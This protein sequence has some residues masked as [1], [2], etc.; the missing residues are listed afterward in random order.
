[1]GWFNNSKKSAEE[2]LAD[3][4]L[5]VGPDIAAV[6]TIR[7]QFIR[8]QSMQKTSGLDFLDF[9]GVSSNTR[10]SHGN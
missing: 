1:M 6:C 5:L 4:I 10:N 8:V 2:R 9:V 3:N 7:K